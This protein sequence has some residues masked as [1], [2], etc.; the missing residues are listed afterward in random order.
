MSFKHYIEEKS[1]QFQHLLKSIIKKKC[2]ISSSLFQAIS[3]SILNG[4][5]H[6]RPLIIYC[7]GESLGVQDIK[8]H[9]LAAAVELI[10][11]YSLVHD[12][13]PAMD[14]ALLRR[15]KPC[16]HLKFGEAEAILAG[17]ALQMLAIEVLATAPYL[18]DRQKLKLIRLLSI[19]AGANGMVGGQSLDIQ[20]EGK[21][22]TLDKLREIHHLKTGKLIAA[23]VL[24]PAALV[25]N[26]AVDSLIKFADLLGVAYQIQD[27]LLDVESNTAVLGKESGSDA[28]LLKNTYPSLMGLNHAKEH[29]ASIKQD[30]EQI[31][32]ESNLLGSKLALLVEFIFNRKN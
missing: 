17:D 11:A 20:S 31:L 7:A 14:N 15:G 10:H 28:K 22:L 3:Y 24:M 5:K 23:C 12:D 18:S 4:G 6:I 30:I 9:S 8:L 25:S 26:A 1:P 13:L 32:N 19:A 16:C 29:L 2:N 21:I 27:D